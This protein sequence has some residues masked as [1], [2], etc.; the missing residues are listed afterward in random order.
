[1]QLGL[2]DEETLTLLN[3]LTP[4]PRV[5]VLR[6]ILTKVLWGELRSGK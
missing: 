1:M 5:L 4:S 3:L 2:T 6:G